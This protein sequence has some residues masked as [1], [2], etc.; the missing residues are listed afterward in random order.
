MRTVAF[1]NVFLAI[2]LTGC[3]AAF[4]P[5]S[6]LVQKPA[7]DFSLETLDGQKLSLSQL[8]GKVVMLDFFATWC[9]SCRQSLVLVQKM[10]SRSDLA[11]RGLVIC[12]INQREDAREI[13]AFLEQTHYTFTVLKDVDGNVADSYSV[14]LFPTTIV[15]GRDGAVRSTIVSFQAG[16]KQQIDA[17]VEQALAEPGEVATAR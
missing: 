15:V 14:K 12:A 13:R 6:S 17:A 16:T 10:A 5:S 8:K 4:D 7:P 3:A 1:V 11:Q 9:P 2:L